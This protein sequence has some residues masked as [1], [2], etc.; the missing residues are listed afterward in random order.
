[1]KDK[2]ITIDNKL[3]FSGHINKITNK[4]PRTLN[5]IERKFRHLDNETFLT[6]SKAKIRPTFEYA[7]PFGHPICKKKKRRKKTKR[8]KNKNIS[9]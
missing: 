5:G 4:V 6:L 2:G 7:S 9:K 3:H 8:K 1:E